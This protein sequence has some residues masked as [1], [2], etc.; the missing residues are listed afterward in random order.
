MI[1]PLAGNDLLI[2]STPSFLLCG[3]VQE[4]FILF[5]ETTTDEYSQHL[6]CGD[7]IVISAPEGGNIRQAQILLELIRTWHMPLVVLPA[8]H[9]GCNR[10]TM[11]VSAGDVVSLN[12]S[13]QR[14]TH[15]EQ[16]VICSSKELS[17]IIL[18]RASEDTIQAHNLPESAE[19]L[20][21]S[22]N[23]SSI[24]SSPTDDESRT[25]AYQ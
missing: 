8:G 25:Q 3:I 13:V 4:P 14:G 17:G 7:I 22:P 2:R 23:G 16:T 5:I 9:P 6:V 11:V 24:R 12:C 15:P 19:I 18:Q 1:I 20:F 21:L 10:L